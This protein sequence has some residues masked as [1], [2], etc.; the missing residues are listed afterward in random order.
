MAAYYDNYDYPSYWTSRKYEH[1]SEIFAIRSF[2]QKVPKINKILEIGAGYGRLTAT[3]IFR[4]HK[5]ILTD[6]SAQLLRLARSKYLKKKQIKFIQT[7]IQNLPKKIKRG[8]VDVAIMIRVLHHLENPDQA[9]EIVSNLLPKGGYFILEFANKRHLKATI[10]QFLKGN[11]TF[12]IDIFPTDKRN[13]KRR[14][15]T[16]PFYNYHP[17]QIVDKLKAHGFKIIEKRSVS[18]IR[19]PFFKKI[20]TTHALLSA[21]KILQKPL[22]LF[23]FGPSI[24]ILA[25]KKD[26]QIR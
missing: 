23:N 1:Q 20:F 19:S 14:K 5:V 21:E 17:D 25:K 2:L 13:T 16:L 11:F 7:T 15:K 22:S 9:F 10:S 24:F 3:Y 8:T 4:A 6:P 12:P 18:N 26:K